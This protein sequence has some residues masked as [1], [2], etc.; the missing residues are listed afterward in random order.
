MQLI[1]TVKAGRVVPT[2][3]AGQEGKGEAGWLANGGSP[4]SGALGTARPTNTFGARNLAGV[5]GHARQFTTTNK[6]T[7]ES[8]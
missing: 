3:C 1:Y 6:T 5:A 8:K 4:H 2:G 7:K